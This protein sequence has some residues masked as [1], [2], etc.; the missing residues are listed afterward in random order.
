MS[1]LA[2]TE[3]QLAWEHR[4]LQQRQSGLSI[5]KWCQQNH[6]NVHTFHY[7]KGKLCSSPLQKSSFTELN[8]KRSEAISLQARGV[9]IRI[10]S[11]CDPHLRKQLFALLAELSC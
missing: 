7:W 11:D 5:D 1:R 6:I 10:G 2:S 8:V 3:K 9:S 4:V